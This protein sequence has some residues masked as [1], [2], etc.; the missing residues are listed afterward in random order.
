[1]KNVIGFRL[2]QEDASTS[3]A[4]ATERAV[5]VPV[6]SVVEVYFPENGRTYPYYNDLYDLQTGDVVFVSGKL[7]G[8]L[9]V[10]K[11]VTTRFKVDLSVYKK[12]IARPDFRLGGTF[13]PLAG[14]MVSCGGSATPD[15]ALFRTWVRPPLPDAPAGEIV[16]GEGYSFDL[17]RLEQSEDLTPAVISKA[18]DYCNEGRVRYLSLQNGVGTAFVEGSAWYEVNFRCSA[19]QV[20][21]MYCECPY[22]G[23]CKHNLAVLLILRTLL[24]ELHMSDTPDFIAIEQDFFRRILSISKQPVTV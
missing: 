4:P 22:P 18:I 2:P 9:G 14:M 11:S 19:G 16:C 3:L 23:L 8:K 12:V 10:V 1:M 24:D 21:D 13:R 7:A 20:T 15:A 5:S 6:R 17:S